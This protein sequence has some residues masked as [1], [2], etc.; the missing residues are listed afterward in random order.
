MPSFLRPTT[1]AFTD[2][3]K[4]YGRSGWDYGPVQVKGGSRPCTGGL[5]QSLFHGGG[6]KASNFKKFEHYVQAR[7]PECQA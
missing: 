5:G 4:N 2:N 7:D 3:T 1:R 6:L